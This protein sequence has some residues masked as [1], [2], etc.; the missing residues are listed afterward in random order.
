MKFGGEETA[1]QACTMAG[2]GGH[3][4]TRVIRF[5]GRSGV[6]PICGKRLDWD[7]A[8]RED[9]AGLCVGGRP[10]RGVGIWGG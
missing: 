8:R 4:A 10:L 1:G 3:W 5:N 7:E 6:M 9:L 2:F